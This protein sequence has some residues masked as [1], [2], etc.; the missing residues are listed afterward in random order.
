MAHNLLS[1]IQ[2]F[3]FTRHLLRII[4]QHMFSRERKMSIKLYKARVRIKTGQSSVTQ[5]VR[6]QADSSFIAKAM[7]QAQYGR[8]CIVA[9]PIEVR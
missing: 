5:E 2:H 4:S 6:V 7:L 8:D 3:A 9:A 1:D